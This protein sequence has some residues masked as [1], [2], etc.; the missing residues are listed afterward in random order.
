MFQHTVFSLP[1]LFIGMVT[2]A[3]GWF[4]WQLLLLG[5][6]AALFARN[7]AMTLN[8]YADRA[9][10]AENPRT[11][12]RPSVDGRVGATQMRLLIA[13]NALLFVVVA[14]QINTLAFALSFPVL[15]VLGAYSY[16]KRFSASAH[17]VLG[18]SLGLAP[19][20]GEIA[21]S[22]EVALWGVQL[23]IGVMFWVAGFDLLYSLQDVEFD[24]Q[25]GLHSVPSRYGV[26]CT[27]LLS[28]IFHALAVLFWLFFVIQAQLG[29]IAWLSVA[30]AALMLWYEQSLVARDFKT[31][32]RAFFTV[33]GYL[34]FMFLGGIILDRVWVL[35]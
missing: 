33:N 18:L 21:V 12:N 8:R 4:G 5:V 3:E 13:L 24:R 26:P 2:A 10:D 20:A 23:G 11:R 25:S 1:F 16:F 22:G 17:L 7:F 15:G 6:L 32:D 28:K 31:I 19:L 29:W 27:L 14:Y 35:S 9:F 30:A 34:G